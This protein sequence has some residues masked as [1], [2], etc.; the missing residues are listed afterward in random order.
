MDSSEVV[1][2]MA[3]RAGSIMTRASSNRLVWSQL[4]AGRAR[5]ETNEGPTDDAKDKRHARQRHAGQEPAGQRSKAA[6][7]QAETTGSQTTGPQIYGALLGRILS[8]SFRK[9]DDT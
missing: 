9:S 7:P 4:G 5:S 3:P 1:I 8:Y 6:G 2:K